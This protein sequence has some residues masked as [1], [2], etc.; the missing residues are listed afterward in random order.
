MSV[1]ENRFAE[2]WR[3]TVPTEVP[4]P[5]PPDPE[6]MVRRV[7]AA[8]DGLP[9]ERRPSMG[10]KFR[11][12]IVLAAV[13][14]VLAGAA[15]A[16]AVR[17]DVLDAF[18][19][20]DTSSAEALVDR[21]IRSVSDKD[22][23][24]TVE[25]SVSD[26]E[27]AYLVVRVDAQSEKAAA[28]LR[29]K[30]FFDADTFLICPVS[31]DDRD[32]NNSNVYISIALQT[33]I[34]ELGEA[35]TETSR[36]WR[37]QAA[38]ESGDRY[39]DVRLS[40]MEP[41]AA[42]TVPLSP[43]ESITVQ[44]GATGQGLPGLY[45]AQGGSVRLD[46]VTLSPFSCRAEIWRADAAHDVSP[47]FFFLNKDETLLTMGQAIAQGHSYVFYEDGTGSC[48]YR[49]QSVMD[50]SQLAA[51]VF[52]GIAYPLDGGKPYSVE[53]DPKLYPFYLP[54]MDPITEGSGYVLPVEA[55]CQ[56]LGA[57]YEWDEGTQTATCTYRE[58]T[59]VLTVGSSTALVDGAPEDLGEPVVL[60]DGILGVSWKLS[61]FW[62]LD[63]TAAFDEARTERTYWVVIP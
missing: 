24:L 15:L 57:S 4:C 48:L 39:L 56:A 32:T 45:H 16:V 21:E 59:I 7:N 49:F 33:S 46:S 3:D 51:V 8:L 44:I 50:L 25:S 54:L 12:S 42:L 17:F 61:E 14:A 20:G 26:G 60:R 29:S 38:L 23:T 1:K 2:F 22:Y 53:I 52:D 18:F 36:T 47:L 43:A 63:V 35:A 13:L 34:E 11:F 31:G 40:C 62:G 28:A 55:L 27:T 41:D 30:D 6:D 58:T 10:Q 5:H 9:S 37:I 19:Q